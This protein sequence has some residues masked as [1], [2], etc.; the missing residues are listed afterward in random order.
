MTTVRATAAH[1]PATARQLRIVETSGRLVRVVAICSRLDVCTATVRHDPGAWRYQAQTLDRSQRVLLASSTVV[2]TWTA[3]TLTIQASSTSATRGQKVTLR[4][5]TDAGTSGAPYL[6][7]IRDLTTGRVVA[8]CGAALVCT[9][10]VT[11]G[12]GTRRYEA[13]IRTDRDATIAR[14]PLVTVTWR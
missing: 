6:F 2:V 4:A 5:T 7:V 8:Y 11:S 9:V 12:K 13:A 3:P 1:L 14:S 10:A